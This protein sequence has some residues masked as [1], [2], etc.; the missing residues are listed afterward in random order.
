MKNITDEDLILLFY[1]EHD[2]PQ[3]AQQVAASE[4][5][6]ARFEQLSTELSLTDN[7]TP[8]QRDENYGADVWQRISPQLAEAADGQPGI[9]GWLS[10]GWFGQLS[11]PS[12]S[13]AGATSLVVVAALAFVIGRQGGQLSVET[14]PNP[15]AGEL[16]TQAA[17]ASGNEIPTS[18]SIDSKR[19]LTSSVASHL[20]QVN[21]MLTQFANTSV[22]TEKDTD[23]ATD[24]LVA[25]RLY[26]QA[27]TNQGDTQLAGFLASLEPLMI[28]MAYEAQNGS[29]ATRERMQE[30]VKNG[31]LFRVRVMNNQLKRSEVSL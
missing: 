12:I 3:L 8:P 7:Y 2:D 14:A 29:P 1:G 11:A 28:E 31:L 9:K 22:S 23:Y 17:N 13:F 25:N 27:A 24:M 16:V 6:S 5:L 20:E 4:K 21:L 19:L 30:E 26:R 15:Q 18:L 10:S